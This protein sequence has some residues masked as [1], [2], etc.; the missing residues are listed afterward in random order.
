MYHWT[1]KRILGHLALCYISF[2]LL[3]HLQLRLRQKQVP[4]TE[5]QIRKSLMKMQVSLLKQDK[6]EYYMT[7]KTP[8]NAH[9]I[10]KALRIRSL[11][12]LIPKEAI[13]TYL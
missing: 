13:N 12:D 10:M 6:K 9:R 8:E 11:P 7:S 5:N 2:T 4:L 3:N 1:E